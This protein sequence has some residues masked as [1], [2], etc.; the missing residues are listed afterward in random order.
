MGPR[1]G[2]HLAAMATLLARDDA[3]R[4]AACVGIYGIYDLANRNRLRAP[5]GMIPNTVMGERYRDAPERYHAVSPIDQ[6][7]RCSPPFLL[8]HGTRDTLVPIGEAEQFADV[9]RRADRP[10]DL[11]AVP[12]AEHAFDAVSSITSRTTAAVI[13]DWLRRTVG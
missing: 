13:R 9:L 10:V 1:A 7:V 4:V 11:V 5:W 8:V 3:E 6:D 12:G 2:T